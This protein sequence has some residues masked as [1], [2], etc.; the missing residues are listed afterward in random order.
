MTAKDDLRGM[1]DQLND[2]DAAEI[3]AYAKWLLEEGRAPAIEVRP[4]GTR[5]E[6]VR[7]AMMRDEEHNRAHALDYWAWR[8]ELR[9]RD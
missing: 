2:D 8:G 1:I 3:F 7:E 9:P 4:A 6:T 5:Q